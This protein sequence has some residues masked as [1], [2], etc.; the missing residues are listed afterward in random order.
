MT[1]E[2]KGPAPNSNITPGTTNRLDG[3]VNALSTDIVKLSIIDMSLQYTSMENDDLSDDQQ[4]PE[5]VYW[6]DASDI[7]VDGSPVIS[8]ES[9]SEEPVV[10]T[11]SV[12]IEGD[13]RSIAP[14][15]RDL[16]RAKEPQ[17]CLFEDEEFVC[18]DFEDTM[19]WMQKLVQRRHFV[20]RVLKPSLKRVE[21]QCGSSA[22]LIGVESDEVLFRNSAS[23][24]NILL[25]I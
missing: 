18:V 24:L 10:S 5:G 23:N 12:G 22:R 16:V 20:L 13:G 4:E 6:H 11:T 25:F 2:N 14:A 17:P 21:P 7:H 1:S 9:N 15:S 3:T 19:P 8:S